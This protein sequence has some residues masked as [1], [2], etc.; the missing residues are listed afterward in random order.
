MDNPLAELTPLHRAAYGN[1]IIRFNHLLE[2]PE[3]R[4]RLNGWLGEQCLKIA[5]TDGHVEIVKA[6]ISLPPSVFD[7]TG[8]A[9]PE[10]F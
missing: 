9:S 10:L 8:T 1:D 4:T 5:V 2:Q 6:L 3:I 7:W